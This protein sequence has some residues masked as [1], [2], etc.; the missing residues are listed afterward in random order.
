MNTVKLKFKGRF[1][2]MFWRGPNDIWGGPNHGFS[3]FWRGHSLLLPP[4]PGS[5]Y[6]QIY[7]D[8]AIRK[9]QNLILLHF[10]ITFHHCLGMKWSMNGILFHCFMH[11]FI[12]CIVI[13]L[14]H[15]ELRSQVSEFRLGWRYCSRLQVG[16]TCSCRP[17]C[18][19]DISI[20]SRG[21]AS[22]RNGNFWKEC[23]LC[24]ALLGSSAKEFLCVPWFCY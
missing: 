16:V 4:P 10:C 23:L 2:W 7:G 14:W 8:V 1:S 17:S 19:S 13:A 6:G 22:I 24:H 12:H 20:G 3:A 5:A 11:S 21:R 15:L 9:L 18:N